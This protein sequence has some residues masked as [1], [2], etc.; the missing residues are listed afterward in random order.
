MSFE[1]YEAQLKITPILA[2]IIVFDQNGLGLS[3]AYPCQV[4]NK[5]NKMPKFY[6]QNYQS[7]T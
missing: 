4:S 1:R 6:H 7:K 3:Q 2:E 5:W